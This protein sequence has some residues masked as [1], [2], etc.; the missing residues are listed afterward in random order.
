[1]VLAFSIKTQNNEDMKRLYQQLAL[2]H[3]KEEKQMLFLMGPRQVGKSTICLSLEKEFPNFYYYNWDDDIDREK[4]LKGSR[5]IAANAHLPDITGTPLISFDELHKYP[6]WKLFLKGLYDRYSNQAKILVTGSARLNVYRRGGDSLMG[7]YFYYRVHPITVAEA[8]NP[9]HIPSQ[10]ISTPRSIEEEQFRSLWNF[11]GFPDPFLKQNE[12][13]YNRWKKLRNEQLFQEDLRDLTQIQSI[14]QL[15]L[16]AQN[17]RSHAG[18]LTNY[19]SLAN[20][21][22]V[23]DTTIRKWLKLLQSFYFCFEV[24]PWS[25]NVTRSLL[26]QPKYYLWDWSLCTDEGSRAENFI[27][28]HLHKAI[29]FW[30]D[31]G[32]GEFGLYFL[33][34]KSKREVDFVVTKE[35]QPWFLVE[36]KLR[37]NKGLSSSLHYFH[38]LIQPKHSFQVVLDEPFVDVDCFSY[39]EPITV[40]GRTFLSQLV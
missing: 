33:R 3:L 28:S 27:A 21:V 31:H 40:P 35:G 30:T 4:I 25:K 1:M 17:I 14:D 9:D 23:A 6:R 13:F 20:K 5:E 8:I 37:K 32:F 36:V 12:Q 16:L 22:R 39:S 15:E 34:D 38:K 29:H 24:R 26:K 7:R 19:G 18:Q 10:L 11:G 2:H